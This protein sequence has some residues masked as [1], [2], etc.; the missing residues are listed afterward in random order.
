MSADNSPK[1]DPATSWVWLWERKPLSADL[2]KVRIPASWIPD[3]WL[4][5]LQH[6]YDAGDRVRF[7]YRDK[8]LTGTIVQDQGR[9][10]TVDGDTPKSG[11]TLHKTDVHPLD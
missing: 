4:P 9:N 11:F 7:T 3:G 2:G 8:E 1:T 6:R 5:Q 10:V